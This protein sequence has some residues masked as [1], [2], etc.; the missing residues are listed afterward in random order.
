MFTFLEVLQKIHTLPLTEEILLS[1]E[2]E[3]K[4]LK[5]GGISKYLVLKSY[6]SLWFD[7]EQIVYKLEQQ[8]ILQHASKYSYVQQPLLFLTWKR[9]YQYLKSKYRT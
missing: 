2:G 1:K 5:G 3:K 6:S 4:C 7:I 8:L 9:S